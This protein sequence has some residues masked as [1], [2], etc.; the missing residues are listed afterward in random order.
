MRTWPPRPPRA[1]WS[2]WSA[3]DGDPDA[4]L[5]AMLAVAAIN[6]TVAALPRA[7]AWCADDDLWRYADEPIRRP[8]PTRYCG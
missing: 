3:P 6:T 8:S 5:A 2:R 1:G 4:G 7:A